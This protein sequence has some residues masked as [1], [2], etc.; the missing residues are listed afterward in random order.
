MFRY[1]EFP[2]TIYIPLTLKIDD[3]PTAMTIDTAAC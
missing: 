1:A 2:E 3:V